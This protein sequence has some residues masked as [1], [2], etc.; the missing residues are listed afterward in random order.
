MRITLSFLHVFRR[1]VRSLA[2]ASRTTHYP[3]FLRVTLRFLHRCMAAFLHSVGLDLPLCCSNIDRFFSA[4]NRF[5]MDTAMK[6]T[7]FV[8]KLFVSLLVVCATLPAWAASNY[9]SHVIFD[10][11]LTS[12]DY[13][14]SVGKP[15][16]TSTLELQQQ[17]IPVD[18]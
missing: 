11:S 1:M 18:S 2:N 10:N 16:N 5:V 12:D 9:Y 15:S 3:N 17:K 13:F 7:S 14:Y 6:T 8:A 4:L